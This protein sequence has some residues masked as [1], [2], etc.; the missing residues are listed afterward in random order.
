MSNRAYIQQETKRIKKTRKSTGIVNVFD[1]YAEGSICLDDYEDE[2]YSDDFELLQFVLEVVRDEGN[3]NI[4]AI[5]AYVQEHERG[6]FIEGNW[7]T[8]EQVK[9]VFEKV[10]K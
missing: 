9:P 3:P 4:E 6:L 10:W 1:D 2:F 7:Y 5:L 8:W